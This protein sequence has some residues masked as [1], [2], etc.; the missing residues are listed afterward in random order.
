MINVVQLVI[1]TVSLNLHIGTLARSAAHSG[2]PKKALRPRFSKLFAIAVSALTRTAIAKNL[3]WRLAVA[4]RL[5]A[6]VAA[7]QKLLLQAPQKLLLQAPQKLLQQL[8]LQELLLQ[9]P[10]LLLLLL[11]HP[12]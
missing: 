7:H 4:V 12:L 1:Y 9:T 2:P 8:L 5:Q 10:Q 3:G 6:P 11:A